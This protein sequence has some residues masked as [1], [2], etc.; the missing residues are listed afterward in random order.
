MAL[1]FLLWRQYWKIQLYFNSHALG[2][3]TPNDLFPCVSPRIYKFYRK[4]GEIVC[5]KSKVVICALLRD[6][7]SNID[8]IRRKAKSLTSK[9]QDYRILIVENDSSDDTR[10]KLLKWSKEDDKVIVLGCGINS[11]ECNLKFPKTENRRVFYS[12][13][14]KMAYLRNIYL[15]YV[16]GFFS[17]FDYTIVWDMDLLS[18]IY[19]DGIMNSFGYLCCRKHEIDVVCSYGIF[20][21]PMFDL[22]Y[23]TYA[24]S[25]LGEE[26]DINIKHIL[27][28][29]RGLTV[30]FNRGESIR[31]IQSGFSG[32][33]IYKT[34]SIVNKKYFVDEKIECE[35]SSLTK[36]LNVY[37]NPSMINFV[38]RNP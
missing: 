34:S 33:A 5:K 12:R 6:A 3:E 29:R 19:L 30:K 7:S 22:F 4:L 18:S 25:E 16:K 32:F 24:Y 27:D 17:N 2:D 8:Y 9:F 26:F 21:W 37:I 23:D 36:G 20:R 15:D 13:I 11:N 1:V 14:W 31:K 28:L 35:H 38:L 10:K